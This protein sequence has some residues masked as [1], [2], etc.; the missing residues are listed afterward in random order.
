MGDEWFT[1]GLLWHQAYGMSGLFVG[2]PQELQA[3]VKV[4]GLVE[5]VRVGTAVVDS[6]QPIPYV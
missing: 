5:N 6:M 3:N 2:L 4:E 1:R